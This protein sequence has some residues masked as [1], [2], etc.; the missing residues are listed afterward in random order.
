MLRPFV[1]SVKLKVDFES[2]IYMKSID[3][4]DMIKSRISL[5]FLNSKELVFDIFFPFHISV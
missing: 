1:K 5:Y 4:R 2:R 3:G